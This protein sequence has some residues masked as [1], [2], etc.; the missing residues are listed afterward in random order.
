M[1]LSDD[2][3]GYLFFPAIAQVLAHLRTYAPAQAL[4]NLGTRECTFALAYLRTL[5]HVTHL[6]KYLGTWTLAH[7]I[8]VLL[9]TQVF[10]VKLIHIQCASKHISLTLC[11]LNAV[12]LSATQAK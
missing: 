10:F 5:V 2:K 8:F 11:W 3:T 4:A 1:V 9:N 7:C 12:S 6:R